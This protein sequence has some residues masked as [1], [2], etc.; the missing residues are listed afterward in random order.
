MTAIMMIIMFMMLTLVMLMIM[1]MNTIMIVIM[2]VLKT[3]TMIMLVAMIMLKT[4]ILRVMSGQIAKWS[5]HAGS[6]SCNDR[7]C[8]FHGGAESSCNRVAHMYIIRA[9]RILSF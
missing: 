4:M 2:I 1:I 6:R 8:A 5:R 3:V 7:T 9:Q